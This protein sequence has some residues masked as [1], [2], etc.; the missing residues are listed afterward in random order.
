MS[1]TESRP[2]WHLA[3]LERYRLFMDDLISKFGGVCM[4]CDASDQLEF[5]H[6]DWRTKDFTIASNWAMKDRAKF[7]LELLKCQL[8]CSTCHE[9]KT[10]VD[11]QEMGLVGFTHGTVYAWMKVKCECD[12]CVG[13]KMAWHQERN[14]KRRKTGEETSGR[15]RYQTGPAEHGTARRYKQGCKCDDCKAANSRKVKEAKAMKASQEPDSS[16]I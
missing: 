5:D 4:Q 6:V 7:D 11:K 10:Q 2:D 9:E 1:K 3:T 8:L 16:S 12:I 13:A 15:G 14:A